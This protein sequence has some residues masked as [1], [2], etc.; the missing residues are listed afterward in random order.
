MTTTATSV[1]EYIASFP[2]DV[3]AILQRLRE[4]MAAAEPGSGETIRYAMPAVMSDDRY[5]VHYAGWKRH[6]GLYP[7]P[8]LEPDLEAEI[9]PYRA[10]KDTIRLPLRDDIPYELIG[11]LAA[12]LAAMRAAGVS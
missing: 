12:T 7:I 10:A 2:P 8:P 4:T 5:V 11:R 1:D 3:R 9:A 6:I